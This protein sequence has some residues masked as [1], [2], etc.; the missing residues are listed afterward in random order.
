MI[1][2]FE[3]YAH[4]SLPDFERDVDSVIQ[5]A[6]EQGIAWLLNV[7]INIQQEHFLYQLALAKEFGLPVIIH[8]RG[9]FPDIINLVKQELPEHF[10]FHCYTGPLDEGKKTQTLLL[11]QRQCTFCTH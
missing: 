11:S 4:L 1:K 7:G 2:L 10:V 9:A 5:K 6:R 8:S 3:T